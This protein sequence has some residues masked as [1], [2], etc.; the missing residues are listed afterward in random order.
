M[1][2]A[3]ASLLLVCSVAAPF[4]EASAAERL[5]P[6]QFATIQAAVDGAVDGDTVSVAYGTYSE[7]VNLRGKAVVLRARSNGQAIIV[8]PSGKRCIEAISGEPATA[9]VIG[10]RMQKAPAADSG[11]GAVLSSASL[12]FED[13]IFDACVNAEGGAIRMTGGS[14]QI[15]RCLFTACVATGPASGIYGSSGGIHAV[16]SVLAIEQSSFLNCD[17]GCASDALLN[18]GGGSVTIRSSTISGGVATCFGQI[19]NASGSLLVED[20]AFESGVK[21][22]IF[23]WSPYTVRRTTFRGM[24][25]YSVLERRGGQYIVDQCRFENCHTSGPLFMSYYGGEYVI[26]GSTFCSTSWTGSMVQ[27][28]WTDGGGNT[29]AQDCTVVTGVTPVSGP[30]T[31]GTAVTIVGS[32]FPI[33]PTVLFGGGPATN[34]VRLSSSRLSATTPPGLPGMTSVTVNGFTSPNSFYY[35]PE[36]GS[37]LDQSGEVDG[38]DLAI[39]LLD[40]GPCYSNAAP[41]SPEDSTPYMLREEAG[42]APATPR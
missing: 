15:T 31:G 9:A 20:S 2:K 6:E 36:C 38:G 32:D 12:R 39:L 17:G 1:N 34:V 18:D 7:S 26:S 41:N 22:A 4:R 21:A 23:A 16:G 8:A 11:G 29:N 30:S 25:G 5:V 14:P 28:A 33:N 37:D 42:V 3:L 19:Y 24:T 13:C 10:F 40:W 35:R 27:G